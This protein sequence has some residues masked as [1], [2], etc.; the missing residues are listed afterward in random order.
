MK[1]VFI[2]DVALGALTLVVSLFFF[3][4]ALTIIGNVSILQWLAIY[5]CIL[6]GDKLFN[7]GFDL[8]VGFNILYNEEK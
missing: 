1:P 7:Y 3:V 5:F 4:G 8:V 6:I 2:R